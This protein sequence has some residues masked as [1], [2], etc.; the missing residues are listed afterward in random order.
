MLQSPGL[1]FEQSQISM[2][3]KDVFHEE[4][5]KLLILK[6]LKPCAALRQAGDVEMFEKLNEISSQ[7][8]SSC[9]IKHFNNFSTKK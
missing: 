1:F 7:F 5:L 4:S 3:Y 8:L 2:R 9:K 6:G